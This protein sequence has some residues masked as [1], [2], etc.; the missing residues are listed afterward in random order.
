MCCD[1]HSYLCSPGSYSTV[2]KE[3]I[4]CGQMMMKLR[5]KSCRTNL[6]M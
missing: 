4:I 2:Y 6:L 1:S 3:I 5:K